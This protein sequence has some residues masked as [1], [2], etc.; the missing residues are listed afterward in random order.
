M[1]SYEQALTCR[2]NDPD[3]LA[4]RAN[5]LTELGRYRDAFD[6]LALAL[7]VDPNSFDAHL[8]RGNLYS[9]LAR[10]GDALA[11]FIAA[12]RICPDDPD[13][14]FN[15]ALALLCMGRFKDGWDKY[16]YRFKQQQRTVML[17]RFPRPLWRGDMN[18][19][20]M[21]IALVAEQGMGDA[22]QFVRYAPMLAELGAKVVLGVHGPLARLMELAPGVAQVVADGATLPDFDVYCS[23]LSLPMA[24]GTD[25]STIPSVVPYLRAE[26][27]LIAQWREHVPHNGRLRVGVCWA[28]SVAHAGDRL[29]SLSLRAICSHPVGVRNR[30]HQP[31]KRR[32]RQPGRTIERLRRQPTRPEV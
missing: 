13:A 4:N 21:T 15:A 7:R 14:N 12:D 5:V 28:G 9:R 18:I 25:L 17:P 27:A 19:R 29:R 32:E 2:P 20:G 11:D 6:D 26:E 3:A 8:N 16:E 10:M 1:A 24:F 31:A 22:I 23:L 30:F